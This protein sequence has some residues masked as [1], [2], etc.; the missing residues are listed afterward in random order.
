MS[1]WRPIATAPR[2]GTPIL[3]YNPVVG[4]YSTAFTTRWTGQT[5][6][7]RAGTYGGYPCGFWPNGIDSYPFGKWDCQP[8]HWQPQP[9]P[10]A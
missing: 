8:T 4:V 9:E 1:E 10:P 5:T 6:E 7:W 2:D 3:A